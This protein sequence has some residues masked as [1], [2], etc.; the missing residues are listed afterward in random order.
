[1]NTTSPARRPIRTTATA[2]AGGL[3]VLTGTGHT[4]L[5]VIQSLTEAPAREVPTRELMAGT[6]VVL[7]GVERSYWDLFQGFSILMAL[8][9]VGF[10]A[11]LLHALRRAPH[12]V[13]DAHGLLVLCVAVLLPGLA[14]SALLLP[15]PPIVLFGLAL[16]AVLT[17]LCAPTRRAAD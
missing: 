15:R 4:A 7:G 14:I 17:A 8:M 10:G 11:L 6:S 9:I 2:I 5:V 13:L 3:L 1:M 16:A 12:L